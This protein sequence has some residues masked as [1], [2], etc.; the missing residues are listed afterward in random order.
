MASFIEIMPEDVVRYMLLRAY[1]CVIFLKLFSFK[2]ICFVGFINVYTCLFKFL[3]KNKMYFTT[4]SSVTTSHQPEITF[5]FSSMYSNFLFLLVIFIVI[6][7]FLW[8]RPKRT[9]FN[10]FTYDNIIIKI[11]TQQYL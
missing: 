10:V 11:K 5:I 4:L 7:C 6:V 2:K 1:L 9:K 8:C 3:L